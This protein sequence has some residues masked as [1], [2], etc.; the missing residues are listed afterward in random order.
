V[1]YTQESIILKMKL[2]ISLK[3][4]PLPDFD[5]HNDGSVQT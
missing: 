5:E 2:H 4:E 1:T 3:K